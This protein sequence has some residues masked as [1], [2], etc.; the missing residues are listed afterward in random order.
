[1]TALLGLMVT[2]MFLGLLAGAVLGWISFLALPRLRTRLERLEAELRR[3]RAAEDAGAEAGPEAGPIPDAAPA[4]ARRAT[5][6]S[7]RGEASIPAA[8]SVA[9]GAGSAAAETA[10]STALPMPPAARRNPGRIERLATWIRANWMVW[11][12]GLCIGLAGVFLVRYSIEQGYLGPTARVLLGIATGLGLHAFAE[13][14]RR[15][16]VGHYDALAALAG[17]ASL[18]LYAAVLA[19]LHL[20]QL[21]PPVVIFALLALVSLGTMALALHHGPILAML[22]IVG[23]FAVPALLGGDAERLLPVLAY[24]LIVTMAGLVLMRYVYRDWLWWG[25]LAGALFWWWFALHAGGYTQAWLGAYPAVVAWSLLALRWGNYRL[26]RPVAAGATGGS[27]RVWLNRDEAGHGYTRAGLLLLLLAQA[28]S[29]AL[30]PHWGLGPLI[31][32]PLPALLLFASRYNETLRALPWL[33]LLAIAAGLIGSLL[34]GFPYPPPWSFVAID[35]AQQGRVLVSLALLGALFCAAG[36]WHLWVRRD[37]TAAASLAFLAPLVAVALAYVLVPEA[38]SH[39]LLSAV[40]LVVGAALGGFAGKRLREGRTD[41]IAFWQIAAGHLAYSLAA[42]ISLEQA[43]LTLALAVQVLS[44]TWLTR[45]FGVARLHWL[46]KLVLAVILVRLTFNPWLLD[47]APGSHWTLWTY[48]GSLV[49]VWLAGL[50]PVDGERLKLWLRA[51]SVHLL[52]LFLHTGM[53]YWLYD[54]AVFA[55][56]YDFLEVALNT[57]LWCALALLYYQRSVVDA[58][59]RLLYRNAAGILMLLAVMSYLMLLTAMNPLWISA[60]AEAIS[61]TPVFNLLLLAYGLPVVLWAL[62]TRYYEPDL[63]PFF[64]LVAGVGLWVFV[65]LEIRHLWH[66]RLA[67]ADVVRDGEVY[68]YSVVWLVLAVVAMLA[69]TLGGRQ[70]LYRGGMVLLLLVILKIFFV[71]MGGLT[72]LLRALSFMG[73]GL[74]LLGLAFAHQYLGRRAYATAANGG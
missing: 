38:I 31:W 55:P 28:Y 65:S 59:Y 49:L 26:T 9:T 72:G 37:S 33:A 7:A 34:V 3:Q 66:G 32:L 41:A 61:T 56:R 2:L 67:L 48:G 40:S 13:W 27:W 4:D 39:W 69:G 47:Y 63:R 68:T 14:L 64:A 11:L 71:D 57:S 10:A 18:V 22:G 20:Y 43:T 15:R 60:S 1:M 54:G 5:D 24:S 23:A 19:A 52:V 74:S 42:V 36:T 29:I 45:R 58:R 6:A 46:V 8:A 30:D 35:A 17:G 62:A 44:L 51:G 21:W 53:R 73:L 16:L 12:G 50:L 25:T 70:V